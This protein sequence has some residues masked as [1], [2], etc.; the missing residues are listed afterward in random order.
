[1]D[2]CDNLAK[3]LSTEVS[4]VLAE[5]MKNKNI[6]NS[7]LVNSAMADAL[8]D[9]SFKQRLAEKMKSQVCELFDKF[10]SNAQN[11]VTK[12]TSSEV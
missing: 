12:L 2:T 4:E 9:E 6:F 5:N 11:L 7:E 3:F 1:M 10:S 8:T